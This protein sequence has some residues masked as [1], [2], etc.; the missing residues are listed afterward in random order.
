MSKY[1]GF[2]YL[3]WSLIQYIMGRSLHSYYP[4]F[5]NLQSGRRI[6]GRSRVLPQICLF[7]QPCGEKWYPLGSSN[8]STPHICRHDGKNMLETSGDHQHHHASNASHFVAQSIAFWWR[9]RASLAL[10]LVTIRPGFKCRATYYKGQNHVVYKLYLGSPW[11]TTTFICSDHLRPFFLSI[12]PPTRQIRDS[13]HVMPLETSRPAISLSMPF[14]S[15]H[16][17]SHTLQRKLTILI[18]FQQIVI[19]LNGPSMYSMW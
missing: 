9:L 5:Q 16:L 10:T 18:N 6:Q 14:I 19:E 4:C 1:A 2:K 17:I 3:E 15:T 13:C 7:V 8:S 12:F 11:I